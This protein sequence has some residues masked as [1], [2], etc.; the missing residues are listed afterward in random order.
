MQTFRKY[1]LTPTQWS[2]ARKKIEKTGTDPEGETYTY[3]NPDLVAVLVDLG[4]LCQEWGTDAEGNQ[5]CIKQTQRFPLTSFGLVSLLLTST[6]TSCGLYPLAF[7][8]WGTRWT[9]ST[10]KRSAQRIRVQHIANLPR[11]RLNYELDRDIQNGQLL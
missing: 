5:V 2:T 11:L 9:P 3:W 1:E 8:Q 6:N 7:L 4:K 10:P